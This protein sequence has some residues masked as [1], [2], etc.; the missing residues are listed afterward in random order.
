MSTLRTLLAG[1]AL[2]ALLTGCCVDADGNRR[3]VGESYT[4]ADDCN[5]CSCGLFGESYTM[6]YCPD[7]DD[8]S[9]ADG[10]TGDS[11]AE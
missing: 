4:C 10:E 5:T 8:D 11:T 7:K 9:G 6:M 2:S 3:H 1:L